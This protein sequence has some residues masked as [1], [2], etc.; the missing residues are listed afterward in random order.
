[1]PSQKP[2]A[3][4]ITAPLPISAACSIDGISKLQIEAATIT[5]AAKPVN[6][7][8]TCVPSDLFK[9][10]THPAPITVPKNGSRIP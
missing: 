2:A 8:C 9:K 5:P 1:M 6:A 10:N 4:G 7:R 3:A